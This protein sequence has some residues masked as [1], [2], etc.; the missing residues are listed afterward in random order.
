MAKKGAD[1]IKTFV[2][3][4]F[5]RYFIIAIIWV[6]IMMLGMLSWVNQRPLLGSVIFMGMPISMIFTFGSLKTRLV[7]G[8]SFISIYIYLILSIRFGWWDE[9]SFILMVTPYVS[10]VIKPKRSILKYL[11]TLLSTALLIYGFITGNPV[12]WWIKWSTIMALYILFLP[13]IIHSMVH[14]NIDKVKHKVVFKQKNE[15]R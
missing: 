8:L 9:A 6:F 11:V 1:R 15:P 14:K 13:P 5:K 2:S 10:L 4:Y 3:K 12:P 7:N